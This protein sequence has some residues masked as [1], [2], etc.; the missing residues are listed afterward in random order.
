MEVT[1]LKMDSYVSKNI[2]E[3]HMENFYKTFNDIKDEKYKDVAF[4]VGDEATGHFIQFKNKQARVV[5]NGKTITDI[6]LQ[7]YACMTTWLYCKI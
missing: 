3:E 5:E 4:Q 7:F 1:L 6:N 2:S